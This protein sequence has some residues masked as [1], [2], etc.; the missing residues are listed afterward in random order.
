[1]DKG[2]SPLNRKKRP[3]YSLNS[4]CRF[5]YSFD[6]TLS[7]REVID[8]TSPWIISRIK[9][10]VPLNHFG[11]RHQSLPSHFCVYSAPG[12][13]TSSDIVSFRAL[14]RSKKAFLPI[15]LLTTWKLFRTRFSSFASHL[16]VFQIF[17]SDGESFRR[18]GIVPALLFLLIILV[19]YECVMLFFGLSIAQV[20][21]KI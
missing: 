19:L 12:C 18:L 14:S 6:G 17:S 15:G 3:E 5:Y 21:C 9:K 11:D 13:N 1:M 20:F 10:K 2:S 8:I 7:M 4:L 16:A